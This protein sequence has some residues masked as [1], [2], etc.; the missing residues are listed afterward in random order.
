MFYDIECVLALGIAGIVQPIAFYSVA[1]INDEQI[2][3]IL[4][5]LP[6]EVMR[7]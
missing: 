1:C 6:M 4:I 7:K 3:A 5:G 2:A